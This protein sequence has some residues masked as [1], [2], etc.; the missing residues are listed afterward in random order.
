M[1]IL[2]I[3]E[4]D[5]MKKVIFEPHHLSELFSIAGHDVFVIDVP[6]PGIISIDTTNFGKIKNIHRTYEKANVTLIHTPIIPI[7]GISRISAYI[8]SYNFIKKIIKKEKIDVVFMYSIAT[9]AQ[10]VVKICKELKIPIIHRT[11]DII[12]DLVR[13]KYLRKK[14]LKIEKEVY[15]LFD[16]V[17]ANTPHM[18]KWSKEMGSKNTIVIPQ[19]VDSDLMK[20]LLPEQDLLE[21]LEIANN[22]KVVMYL[23]SIECFSGLDI[24]L[25][26]V[27]EIIIK[28]P[29]FKLLIVGG[30]SHLESIKNKTKQMSLKNK[31][32]FTGYV[33]YLDVPKYAS[34]A[35]LCINT[36]VVNS[37]TDKL[38]PVKIFDLLSCGKTIIATPLSGLLFDFPQK[39][40]VLIYS[41][42][43][44][45]GDN[46]ISA[47]NNPEIAEIGKSGRKFIKE[48]FSWERVSKDILK[49]LS[50]IAK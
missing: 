41:E 32:I 39:E 33:P 16:K 1:R 45:F 29:E 21:Q 28:I 46:I 18:E 37:M 38:S 20:P 48:K 4:I 30:G 13:E 43:E 6:D 15:P 40:S 44:S 49:E 23:G 17:I 7:K 36:F 47:L 27:P 31:I 10:A 11:F 25:E 34:L 35:K 12:H 3:H 14:I 19:G 22:D 50:E 5:W 9:N 42:L 2:I 26:Q 24:L 8:T